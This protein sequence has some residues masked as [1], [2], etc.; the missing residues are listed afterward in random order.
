NTQIAH[1]FTIRYVLA[2]SLLAGLTIGGHMVVQY[3]LDDQQNDAYLINYAGRQRFQSQQIMKDVLLLAYES[4]PLKHDSLQ[5]NLRAILLDFENFHYQLKSGRL[6]SANSTFR[7]TLITKKLYTNLEPHFVV[8][9]QQVRQLVVGRL[10]SARLALVVQT[11]LGHE[12]RF[13]VIMNQ[14][15]GQYQREAQ[16]KVSTQASVEKMLII[17]T[18]LVLILEALLIFYPAVLTLQK[19]VA[20]VTQSE[21]QMRAANNQLQQTNQELQ[22]AQEKLL[23]KTSSRYRQKLVDQRLRLG[24]LVQGQEDER[25]R[26]SRELHDGIGQMLTGLKLLA[27]NIRSADQLN[28]KD[29]QTFQNLKVLLIRT[30]QETRDVSNNLMPPY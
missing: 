30:I 21:Q 5:R 25:R 4:S 11:L 22:I 27:E 14:I 23:Q 28:D 6:D 10:S 3:Q 9:S 29:R 12:S 19:T 20:Q 17:A 18:L 26:L 8:I 2:L 13:L 15:V 24:L 1:R 7:N 16:D